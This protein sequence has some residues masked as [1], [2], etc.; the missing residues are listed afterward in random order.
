ML[1]VTLMKAVI[2]LA[3]S[4]SV[5][6]GGVQRYRSMK[7]LLKWEDDDSVV[8]SS[9]RGALVGKDDAEDEEDDDDDDDDDDDESKAS[10]AVAKIVPVG[11]SKS[12]VASSSQ[13]ARVSSDP[14][15]DAKRKAQSAELGKLTL[16]KEDAQKE[17]ESIQNND[18]FDK[19]L[20]N[21]TALIAKQ[22]ESAAL[23]EFL[24][25][26]KK[27]VRKYATPAYTAYLKKQITEAD[28][29]MKGLNLGPMPVK[30]SKVEKKAA[31]KK[32]EAKPE[33]KI[34][35]KD[36]TKPKGSEEAASSEGIEEVKREEGRTFAMAFFAN[37][38]LLTMVFGMASAKTDTVKNY[39]WFIVDQV[40]AI[41][42]AVMYFQ[43][44][45]S[46]LDFHELGVSSTVVASVLH[47]IATFAM[48]LVL[49]YSFRKSA[50]GVAVIAGSGAHLVGFSCIHGTA[51]VQN[52]VFV[53][54]SYTV[55]MAIFGLFVLTVGLIIISF[56]TY[57]AK[58]R[59]RLTGEDNDVF[60]D[61]S[62]D[63]ENDVGAT[64]FSVIF[65]MLVRFALTGHHPVDDDTDFDHTAGERLAMLIYAFVCL[66]LAAGLLGV[67][68][69]N[70]ENKTSY[71]AKRA[72]MFVS[73]VLA[74]NVAWAFLYW[75][76]WQFFEAWYPHSETR[77]RVL[78]AITSSCIAALG[79]V[80]LTKMQK[81]SARTKKLAL[82][83]L[84]LVVAFSW[85]QVFDAAVDQMV[86]GDAHPVYHKVMTTLVMAAIVVPV[87][88]IYMK[89][90]TMPAA[91]AIGA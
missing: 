73:A 90:I 1:A 16:Q 44:F 72:L 46:M 91:E 74:L 59:A 86:E 81:G 19:K 15:A 10:V 68:E 25:D 55:Q 66:G 20:A 37:I 5:E 33:A 31:D 42:L 63:L 12:L 14:K 85:E 71:A 45:D 77:G 84:A 70:L 24:G 64:G 62:D 13:R 6:G 50:V 7:S 39:T 79:I 26:L 11:V 8:S 40:V 60:M 27:D 69:R 43:A 21:A 88:A 51:T 30:S 65:T 87:Y 49:V 56:L 83:A 34:E 67:V 47:A 53:G 29:E 80:I 41:F 78:F 54:Y 17:L 35:K 36:E 52:K 18:A 3:L 75:G 38:A 23:A 4:V 32:P 2:F 89:P 9:L 76:E 22:T 58:Q 57:R 82:T 48:M 28:S 61:K